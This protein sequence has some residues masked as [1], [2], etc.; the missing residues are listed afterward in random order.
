M[1]PRNNEKWGNN[2]IYITFLMADLGSNKKQNLSL[3]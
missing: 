2:N 1:F 3:M